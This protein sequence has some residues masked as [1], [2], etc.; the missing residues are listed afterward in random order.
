[1]VGAVSHH[2]RLHARYTAIE[3]ILLQAH[4][5]DLVIFQPGDLMDALINFVSNLDPN[6]PTL[7]NWPP[8]TPGAPALMTFLDGNTTTQEI[9]NDTFRVEGMQALLQATLAGAT[10]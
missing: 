10:A 7:I 9:T 6:G 3:R 5:N 4:G 2:F 1:M 8:Y